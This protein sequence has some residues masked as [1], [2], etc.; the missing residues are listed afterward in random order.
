MQYFL[1]IKFFIIQNNSNSFVFINESRNEF[2][3]KFDIK[4]DVL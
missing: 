2:I 4:I 3:A 1:K